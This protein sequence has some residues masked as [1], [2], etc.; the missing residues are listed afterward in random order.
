MADRIE[1][2]SFNRDINE[3]ITNLKSKGGKKSR[4][5]DFMMKPIGVVQVWGVDTP[6]WI[7]SFNNSIENRAGVEITASDEQKAIA[8]ADSVVERTQGASDNK[9]LSWLSRSQRNQFI[10]TGMIFMTSMTAIF[11]GVTSDVQGGC[12]RQ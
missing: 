7:A 4:Y 8:Y 6:I 3:F 2:G 11:N 1:M 9:N 10:R 12:K 5:N